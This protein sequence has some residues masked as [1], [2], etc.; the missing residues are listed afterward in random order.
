[1]LA[2]VI[3]AR[4]ALGFFVFASRRLPHIYC[5]EY[6]IYFQRFHDTADALRGVIYSF[7]ESAAFDA[8]ASSCSACREHYWLLHFGGTTFDVVRAL[9]LALMMA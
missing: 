5:R 7:C 9:T 6:A 8:V 2:A 1:M 3:I 4:I